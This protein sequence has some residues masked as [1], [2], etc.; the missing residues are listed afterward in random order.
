V[1]NAETQLTEKNVVPSRQQLT[2]WQ[3]WRV[4]LIG[5]AGYG[6]IAMLGLTLRWRVRGWEHLTAIELSG[7]HPVMAL[8]HGRIL[9]ATLYFRDRGIVVITSENFD[10]E[11]IARIIERFGYGTARGSSS[12]GGKRALIQLRRGMEAGKPVGFTVDGPRGPARHAKFGAVWLSSVTGN[13]ILPFHIEAER[14]W[15]VPSWDETQIPKPFSRMVLVI[16]QPIE[17]PCYQE[18][19]DLEG[20][21]LELELSLG[22]L[23]HLARK[24]LET[25]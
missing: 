22:K 23:T 4:A 18:G 25:S 13:P 14:F 2:P 5:V 19:Q 21:R 9:G 6:I 20:K 12:H 3:R 15:T 11:W 24:T 8:W 17:V 16:G 7:R 1:Q 10:G